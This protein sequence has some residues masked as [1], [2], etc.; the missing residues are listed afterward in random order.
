MDERK[1]ETTIKAYQVPGS[2]WQSSSLFPPKKLKQGKQSKDQI[3]LKG[4]GQIYS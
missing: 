1:M 3:P 2:Q 4:H